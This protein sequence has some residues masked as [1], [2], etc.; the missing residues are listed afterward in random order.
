MFAIIFIFILVAI[1][2][3]FVLKS[4]DFDDLIDYREKIIDY[5]KPFSKYIFMFLCIIF[6]YVAS[7][8]IIFTLLFSIILALVSWFYF[9]SINSYNDTRQ[10]KR[11]GVSKKLIS[12]LYDVYNDDLLLK[13][14]VRIIRFH[15]NIKDIVYNARISINNGCQFHYSKTYSMS[16]CRECDL[17]DYFSKTRD[18]LILDI[19]EEIVG[20]NGFK[21]FSK[22]HNYDQIDIDNM[23]NIFYYIISRPDFPKTAE[24][25]LFPFIDKNIK[26]SRCAISASEFEPILD[27][28]N[29]R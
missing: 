19:S 29:F 26:F 5:L 2:I 13:D 28:Y 14:M 11:L 24:L 20:S 4:K 9:Q 6:I 16:R 7:D 1:L 12:S 17:L 10:A 27:S 15:G 8:S 21:H 23:S 25:F 22:K 18:R 3:Y